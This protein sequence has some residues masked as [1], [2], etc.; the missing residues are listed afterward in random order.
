MSVLADQ[1]HGSD[2]DRVAGVIGE[3][4]AFVRKQDNNVDGQAIANDLAALLKRASQSSVQEIDAI[5][6]QLKLLRD[7]L[8]GDGARAARDLATYATL[9]QSAWRLRE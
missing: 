7:R 8:E 6:T 9:A 4:R 1:N 3:I 2:L 5:V